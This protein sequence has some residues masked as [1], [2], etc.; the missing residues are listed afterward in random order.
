MRFLKSLRVLRRL[1]ELER[2]LVLSADEQAAIQGFAA[3][4]AAARAIE[5]Q[6]KAIEDGDIAA[7]A[8]RGSRDLKGR[9]ADSSAVTER[10]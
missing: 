8:A 7:P 9:E 2:R 1:N 3:S 5:A 6:Q 4:M 10:A